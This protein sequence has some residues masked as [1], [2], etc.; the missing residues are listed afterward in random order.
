MSIEIYKKFISIFQNLG[1]ISI[2][3]LKNIIALKKN[4][5]FCSI[6]IQKK[7]LKIIFRLYTFFSSPRFNTMSQ[8]DQMYYYQ[9][10]IQ[11]LDEINEELINWMHQAY[12]EN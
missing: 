9:F 7:A 3:S 6:Q 11:K 4:S 1:P 8:Q 2:E 10:K 12:I 5:Q